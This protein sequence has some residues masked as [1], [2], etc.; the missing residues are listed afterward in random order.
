[1][2]IGSDEI[3]ENILKFITNFKLNYTSYDNKHQLQNKFNF[4]VNKYDD[5]HGIDILI[6]RSLSC[7]NLSHSSISEQFKHKSFSTSDLKVSNIDFEET[8]DDTMELRYDENDFE[9]ELRDGFVWNDYCRRMLCNY[10]KYP[11]KIK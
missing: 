5:E 2:E 6:P 8:L 10:Y 9:D 11:G 3:E 7:V 4:I 1:M